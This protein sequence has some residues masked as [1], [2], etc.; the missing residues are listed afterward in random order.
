MTV[1]YVH[2]LSAVLRH[3]LWPLWWLGAIKCHKYILIYIINHHKTTL[4]SVWRMPSWAKCQLEKRAKRFPHW[5]E[6]EKVWCAL[7]ISEA[8][9]GWCLQGIFEG[10]FGSVEPWLRQLFHDMNEHQVWSSIMFGIG[11][12]F[13]NRLPQESSGSCWVSL[14]NA[15]LEIYKPFSD[16]LI[17]CEYKGSC[18]AHVSFPF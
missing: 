13:G 7:W 4:A 6:T 16:T 17:Y 5:G 3:P 1:P 15:S 11:S 14:V 9:C 10:R 2:L 8:G 12:L 18:V